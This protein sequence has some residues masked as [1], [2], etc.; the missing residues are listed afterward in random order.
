MQVASL[1]WNNASVFVTRMVSDEFL[2]YELWAAPA[3]IPELWTVL[4]QTTAKPVGAEALEKFRVAIGFPKYGIDIRDRD[5]PQETEQKHALNFTKGCY[6]GQEIVERIRS[7]GNVHRTFHGFVVEG[8]LPEPG[9]KLQSEGRE[10]GEI[11][12]A[13]RIP[14]R[15]GEQFVA[16]GYVRREALDK[17]A[18]LTY[19]GGEA[20]PAQVPFSVAS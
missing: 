9:A 1:T 8:A 7:R 3:V 6:I 4:L 14:T 19:P 13:A 15:E 10:V 11:T 12:S 2:T 5:L 16:L 17:H 20:Q 18:K